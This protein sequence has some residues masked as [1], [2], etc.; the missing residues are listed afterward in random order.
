MKPDDIK[1]EQQQLL[2]KVNNQPRDLEVVYDK[3][4]DLKVPLRVGLRKDIQLSDLP[5]MWLFALGNLSVKEY[6]DYLKANEG[7]LSINEI[8]ASDL[9]A[10]VLRK[11]AEALKT[12]WKLNEKMLANRGVITNNIKINIKP[13]SAMS[14]LLSSIE[15]EIF[16]VDNQSDGSIIEVEPEQSK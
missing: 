13:N 5:V 10:G 9:L 3:D 14:E 6:N 8:T 1:K 12:Y 7:K 2:D 11:D 16:G 4:R 15:G